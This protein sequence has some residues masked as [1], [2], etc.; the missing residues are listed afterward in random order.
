MTG[1]GKG[2]ASDKGRRKTR[3]KKLIFAS[4]RREYSPTRG[5]DGKGGN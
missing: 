2:G 1:G 4:L 5:R 3:G